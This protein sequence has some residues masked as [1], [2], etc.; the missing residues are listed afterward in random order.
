MS[1]AASSASTD[2]WVVDASVAAK[3]FRPVAEEPEGGLAREAIGGLAM[4]ITTL[5]LYEVGNLLTRRA[6]R[7]AEGVR[8]ALSLLQ[9]ICGEP[10]PLLP[11]DH[12][13]AA[14]LALAHRLTFY[15]A[16]YVAIANRLGRRVLSADR[17]LVEPGLAVTLE[18]A[19]GS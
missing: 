7:D 4:R 9:E 5:T 18:T 3:W 6:G 1:S 2:A 10:L 15:D 19:L 12:G 16:S 8:A 14:E 11:E 13:A 17:D